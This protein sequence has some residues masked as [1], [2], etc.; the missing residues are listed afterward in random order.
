MLDELGPALD[1]SQ[2]TSLRKRLDSDDPDQSIPAEYELA[3]GWGL[4]KITSVEVEP[5]FGTK[6]PDYHVKDIFPDRPAVIEVTALSDEALSGAAVMER[7]ANII[8][9]FADSVRRRSSKNLHYTFHETS[10]FRPVKMRV[11]LGHFTHRSQ[12]WRKRLTS[13]NFQLTSEHKS[14]IRAWLAKWPPQ[15]P[16]VLVEGGTSVSV[17]WKEWVHPS[18]KS[19]SSMPSLAHDLRDNPIYERLKEKEKQLKGVPEGHL[20][21]IFLCDAGCRLLLRPRDKSLNTV[22][23]QQIIHEFLRNSR[24][25]IVCILSPRHRNEY[26]IGRH[27][28]PRMWFID[29][30]DEQTRPQGYYSGLEKLVASLPPPYLHGYQARSWAQQ[31]MLSPQGRGHYLPLSYSGGGDRM[32]VRVS[33]RALL[34]LLA[35]RMTP[36]QIKPWVTGDR[37][38]FEDK[39]AQ[40]YAIS[41][42][43]LEPH[44]PNKDDDY[45][46]VEMNPDPNAAPFTL[47]PVLKDKIG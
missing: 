31:G 43:S 1:R 5:E 16:L 10:G 2:A 6:N 21:C 3:V 40:G 8:N 15:R 27:D 18:S 14:L 44:G 9:Q 25:D 29:L 33:A 45:V 39:L 26:A 17:S 11:P 47:P 12:Y 4:N 7:T 20:K 42:I 46:L 28:N 36:D 19:F 41:S 30:F 24:V 35:G 23:G 32:T 34:E 38:P 13:K 22:S 37:N